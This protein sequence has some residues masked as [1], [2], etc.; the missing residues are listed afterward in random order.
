MKDKPASIPTSSRRGPRIKFTIGK[1]DTRAIPKGETTESEPSH[2]KA[3]GV[4]SKEIDSDEEENSS[5]QSTKEEDLA[6]ADFDE[7]N[8]LRL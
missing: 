3:K 6:E 8:I 1:K 2:S 5:D 4:V 7:E